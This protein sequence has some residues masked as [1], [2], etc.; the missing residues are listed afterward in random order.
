MHGTIP[1]AQLVMELIDVWNELVAIR[2]DLYELASD[3]M[4]GNKAMH[5]VA[6]TVTNIHGRVANLIAEFEPP[7]D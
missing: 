7:N 3:V 1:E 5:S 2:E 4:D 6:V